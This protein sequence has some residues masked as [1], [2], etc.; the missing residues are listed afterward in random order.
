[1][2]E[3]QAE[4]RRTEKSAERRGLLPGP[5]QAHAKHPAGHSC[6]PLCSLEMGNGDPK[7]RSHRSPR[8][9]RTPTLRPA[10]D[11]PPRRVSSCVPLTRPRMSKRHATST[12]KAA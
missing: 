11:V 5:A 12:P 6:R 9:C 8:A 2:R 4:P 7:N 1:M 10:S 3:H